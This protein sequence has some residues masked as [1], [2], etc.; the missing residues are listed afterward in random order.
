MKVDI[1]SIV[2][3]DGASLDIEFAKVMENLKFE[4]SDILFDKGVNL[5]GRLININ[6]VIN[7]NGCLKVEY[8]VEC[9]R[10]LKNLNRNLKVML[11]ENFVNTNN[12]VDIDDEDVYLYENNQIVLD[13]VVTDNILLNLPV[14][15]VCSDLCKG[16][17]S[18]CGTNLNKKAC[19]C[20]D[21]EINPQMEKLRDYF[22]Q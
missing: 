15:Q 16:F 5:K 21:E 13:E 17:C 12:N 9:S 22:K 6:G 8:E 7:L 11:N 10:C 18:R 2:S 3:N 4:N 14:K 20:K 19:D 1:S